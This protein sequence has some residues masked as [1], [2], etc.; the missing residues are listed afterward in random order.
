MRATAMRALASVVLVA[1]GLAIVIAASVS[2]ASRAA[3]RSGTASPCAQHEPL[4][5]TSARTGARTALVPGGA[6]QVLLCRYD[7]LND[8]PRLSL[9]GHTLI[10]DESAVVG[11]AGQLNAL[12]E[13]GN[14]TC[15]A[16]FGDAI[17][18]YFGYG[19][20]PDDPVSIGLSG[21][22]T[23]TNGQLTQT[24]S[25]SNVV[26]RLEKLVPRTS[27]PP[28]ARNATISGYV[29]LCG[30]PAPGRCWN[31]AIGTCSP[32]RGCVTTDRIAAIDD[33]G[34][35][36]GRARLHRGRFTVKV[37]A[38]RYTIELLADGRT[39]HGRVTAT[40]IV[41][42]VGGQTATVQFRFDVP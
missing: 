40:R 30:G 15:P 13:L 25:G 7:G 3:P 8:K 12:H 37:P 11:L 16:D 5:V 29:R 9:V 42:A 32:G 34:A 23:V 17:V 22:E 19:A 36:V 31:G 20:D 2:A 33:G 26:P 27:G 6:V 1:A 14:V 10:T 4:S 38:G 24:A 41:T 28:P 35:I 21:C 39:V 18:A